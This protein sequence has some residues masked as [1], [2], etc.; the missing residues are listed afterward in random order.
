MDNQM[1][2]ELFEE[3]KNPKLVRPYCF[4]SAEVKAIFDEAGLAGCD[5]IGSDGHVAGIV[6]HPAK[7][8]GWCYI[9]KPKY[10]P[11]PEYE[12]IKI[13]AISGRLVL[14]R[15][16]PSNSPTITEVVAREN[17]V[18]FHYMNGAKTRI[19]GDVPNWLRVNFGETMYV[20]FVKKG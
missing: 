3:L 19:P 16:S 10:E 6:N 8:P 12:D 11:A 1:D 20:R 18:C 2:K 7:C 15:E 4:C 14:K 13:V 5:R 17:F 9:L